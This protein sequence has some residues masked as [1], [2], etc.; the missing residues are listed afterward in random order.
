[1]EVRE[2]LHESANAAAL[3]AVVG[4]KGAL[5]VHGRVN[6]MCRCA[7]VQMCKYGMLSKCGDLQM[8]AS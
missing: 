4:G 2:L 3:Q 5:V 7:D 8:D 6:L 1:M